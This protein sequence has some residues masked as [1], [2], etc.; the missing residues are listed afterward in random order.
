MNRRL[1]ADFNGV[2]GSLLC[3]SHD[4]SA[5][6]EAGAPVG[7]REGLVATAFER[8]RDDAGE[9]EDLVATGAVERAPEWLQ[10]QGSRWVLRIDGRGI[11]HEAVG[12][13]GQ[14]P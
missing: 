8:D 10:C 13:S 9:P 1:R 2:F 12:V 7:L 14:V 6:D 3:L 11:R 5:V 4:E